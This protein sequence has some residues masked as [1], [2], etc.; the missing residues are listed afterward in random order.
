MLNTSTGKASWGE[1][2]SYRELVI[3]LVTLMTINDLITVTKAR[4]PLKGIT[5]TFYSSPYDDEKYGD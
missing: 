5:H 2:C 4:Q 1:T 3:Q